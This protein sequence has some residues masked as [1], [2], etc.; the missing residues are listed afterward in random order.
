MGVLEGKA[1]I[2]TG[3]ARGIG[4][5]AAELLAEH[6]ARVLISDVDADLARQVAAE[7]AG[8]TAVFGGDLTQD[9][10][11][12][13]LVKAAGDAFGQIDIVVNNAGYTWDGMAHK[14]SDEQFRAMLEIHTVVPFKVLRAAAPYLRDAGKADRGSGPRG[15]PQGRQ[16][17]V[18]LG[19]AGEPRPGRTIRP[20]RPDSSG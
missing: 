4:R 11:A 10:A 7:I 12:E 14:M 17:H 1:A 3:S 18:D 19:N 13:A 8:E 15:V 6:G 16:R 9:G 2:V 20:R 5:A